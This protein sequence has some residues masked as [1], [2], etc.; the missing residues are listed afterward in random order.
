MA[1]TVFEAGEF[2]SDAN[3]QI[4][5]TMTKSWMLRALEGRDE[6]SRQVALR[7][8]IGEQRQPRRGVKRLGSWSGLIHA[9]PGA[10]CCAYTGME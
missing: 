6:R 10:L 5:A 7:L 1:R 8:L 4:C 2:V 9:S 3:T